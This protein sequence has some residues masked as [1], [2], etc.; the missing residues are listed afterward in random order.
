M[1]PTCRW[2]RN[3]RPDGGPPLRVKSWK[4]LHVRDRSDRRFLLGASLA[5]VHK[6]HEVSRDKAGHLPPDWGKRLLNQLAIGRVKG[7]F[8]AWRTSI[9]RGMRV[10][11]QTQVLK[12]FFDDRTLVDDKLFQKLKCFNHKL[13]FAPF[14]ATR[15]LLICTEQVAGGDTVNRAPQLHR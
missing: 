7:K 3:R 4:D 14:R 8:F 10:L 13:R 12:N 6:P 5:Y 15:K 1:S 9:W 11:P 2:E